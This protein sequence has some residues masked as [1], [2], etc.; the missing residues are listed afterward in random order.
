[1]LKRSCLLR[2]G[3]SLKPQTLNQKLSNLIYKP[4]PLLEGKAKGFPSKAIC[5]TNKRERMMKQKDKKSKRM[6]VGEAERKALAYREKRET[7]AGLMRLL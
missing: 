2:R 6:G 7:H 5:V 3:L 1:M 4:E